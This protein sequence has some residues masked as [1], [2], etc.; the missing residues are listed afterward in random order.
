METTARMLG[1]RRAAFR[2]MLSDA[3][4]VLADPGDVIATA[5]A[6]LGAELSADSNTTRARYAEIDELLRKLNDARSDEP[7]R[8]CKSSR[9]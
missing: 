4:A 3:L 9:S 8:G 2:L 1:E 6:L 5:S 7:G